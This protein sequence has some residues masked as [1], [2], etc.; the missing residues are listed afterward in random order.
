MTGAQ[1]TGGVTLGEAIPT[2]LQATAAANIAIGVSL[3]ELQAKLAGAIQA[4]A[5]VSVSPPSFAAALEFAAQLTAAANLAI[6]GPAVNVDVAAIA[7]F[8]AEIEVLLGQLQAQASVVLGLNIL[9]GTAGVHMYTVEDPIGQ[10]G[11][12]LQAQLAGGTPGGG[13]P[14]DAGFGVYLVGVDSGVIAALRTVFGV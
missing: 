11:N 9:F 7:K 4:Q 12:D 14:D 8:I 10:H 6:S 2:A 1:Y 3:P 5:S 13:G